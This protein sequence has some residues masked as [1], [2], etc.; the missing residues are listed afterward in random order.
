MF[1]LWRLKIE[2]RRKRMNQSN[3]KK[4]GIMP[5]SVRDSGLQGQHSPVVESF[6]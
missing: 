4:Q 2:T 6:K 1:L 3:L 5:W